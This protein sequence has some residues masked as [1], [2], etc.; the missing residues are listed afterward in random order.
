MIPIKKM[1]LGAF[2]L[3]AFASLFSF[4]SALEGTNLIAVHPE[5][6]EWIADG[7]TVYKVNVMLDNTGMSSD[8]WAAD[9]RL[10][11]P[12][13]FDVVSYTQYPSYP[14][15]DFFAGVETFNLFFQGDDFIAIGRAGFGG[16]SA[17]E[18]NLATYWFT[19]SPNAPRGMSDLVIGEDAQVGDGNG[20]PQSLV[21][22][23]AQINIVS[24]TRCRALSCRLSAIFD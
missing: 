17:N 1:F 7:Q 6:E 12:S 20:Q 2:V 18:G 14:E 19:V 15:D 3:L 24:P 23:N 5:Q 16:V 22:E 11:F 13:H 9:W 4:T 21:I 10:N 8:T